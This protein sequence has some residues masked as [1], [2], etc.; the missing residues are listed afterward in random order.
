MHAVPV[1]A[2]VVARGCSR[3]NDE[4]THMSALR[5]QMEADMALRGLAYRTRQAYVESVA[6]LAKFYGRSP[7]QITEPECQSYLLHLL[8]ERKLA[9]S[10]CNVVCSALQF[11]YRVT[12]KRREAEFC[13]PRPKVP[14]K[15]P[16]ILSREEIALLLEKTANVKHRAFLMTT[17]GA[18]LRLLEAC[19][20]QISDIDSDRM[21]LRVEQG[22][23]AKD[24]YTLLSPRLLTQLRRYWMAERPQRW[25]FPSP[26]DA[27]HP[28]L[29]KSAQRIFYA[30]KDRAGITKDCGI[31]GLRHA[32]A[33]HLLEAGVDVHTI[34]RL[35][36]HGSLSTTARYFHLAQKHL[37]GTASPLELLERPDS[38]RF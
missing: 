12:L 13:L 3:V 19:Q 9:H 30:A 25:L 23:G 7:E 33:T 36:G 32:F 28:M 18:G 15:L 37:S 16:Q 35:M 31:H 26:R 17:Y 6:K 2:S 1:C 27:D 20:L 29:P 38:T 4:E 21:T 14:A 22:K 10:S 11:F 24:R 8:Q 34:Q 5:K